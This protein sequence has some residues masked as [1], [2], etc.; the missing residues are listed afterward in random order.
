MISQIKLNCKNC[1]KDFYK[2]KSQISLRKAQIKYGSAKSGYKYCSKKCQ[3]LSQITKLK[4]ICKYCETPFFKVLAQAKRHP[5]HFC[6]HSCAATY[7]NTH[8]TKGY[9]RSKLE[10]WLESQLPLLYPKLIFHF[11]KKDAINSELDIY[12][13]KLKLAFELNG[14]FHYE[15][16]FGESQLS[17][18]QNNDQR[19]FQACLE[20][21][22]ELCLIDV[23]TFSY[24]KSVYAQKYLDM[25]CN[26]L[27]RKL[28]I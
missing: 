13:P 16:I 23:S 17:K 15:P 12:I 4:C 19:K 3:Y 24:F 5:N 18:I 14:I 8:K 6:S 11:N 2:T 7:N 28:L 20:H 27:N 26:I 1:N 21:G 9:R 22:I 10:I 25:I